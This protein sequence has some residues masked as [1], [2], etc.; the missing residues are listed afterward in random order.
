MIKWIQMPDLGFGHEN[1]ILQGK[2]FHIS[3]NP[4][5][6][7]NILTLFRGEGAETALCIGDSFYILQ[8]DWRREYE[9]A[10]P[11]GLDSCMRVY[12]KNKR[13]FA[14]PWSNE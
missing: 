3:Y 2:G 5:T 7:H 11:K 13:K 8:G 9:K 12:E 10:F 1:Y 4:D 14:S 6:S